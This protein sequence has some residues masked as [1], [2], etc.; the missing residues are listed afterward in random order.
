MPVFVSLSCLQVGRQD[1]DVTDSL[2]FSAESHRSKGSTGTRPPR[3]SLIQLPTP[4]DNYL[5][6]S[7]GLK[8]IPPQS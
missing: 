8:T 2:G 6:R 1:R 3:R 4:D 5:T 7:C